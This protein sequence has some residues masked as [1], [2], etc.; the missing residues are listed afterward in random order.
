VEAGFLLEKELIVE[1][2]LK[3][4]GGRR[5][6][7]TEGM[8]VYE[9]QPGE[10]DSEKGGRCRGLLTE[11]KA[12]RTV[13]RGG[14]GADRRRIATAKSRPTRVRQGKHWGGG[15][16]RLLGNSAENSR[17]REESIDQGKRRKWFAEVCDPGKKTPV[18]DRRKKIREGVRNRR[19]GFGVPVWDDPKERGS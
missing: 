10:G 6:V 7:A 11:G 3:I 18:S 1:R 5:S 17:I 19:S 9:S 15:P 12:R 2:G 4:L 14:G 16:T 8:G 13:T